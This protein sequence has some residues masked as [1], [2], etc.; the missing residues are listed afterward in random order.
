MITLT[1]TKFYKFTYIYYYI[2]LHNI[3]QIE[4]YLN[5]FKNIDIKISSNKNPDL[6]VG[7]SPCPN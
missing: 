6:P 7:A 3:T 4:Y 5:W 2:I 1:P